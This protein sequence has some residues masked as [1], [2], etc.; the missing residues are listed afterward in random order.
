MSNKSKAYGILGK[1]DLE[2]QVNQ[3]FE[4]IYDQNARR[5]L[6]VCYRMLGDEQS[7]R[8]VAQD[9]W[10]KAYQNLAGFEG[11]SS[12]STWLYRIAVNEILNYLK[13][14]KRRRK[15][16]QL[17][18]RA[19]HPDNT[20]ESDPFSQIASSDESPLDQLQAKDRENIIW[21]LIQKLPEKQKIPLILFRYESLSYQEVADTMGI[22]LQAVESRLHRAKLNLQELLEPFFKKI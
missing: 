13:K 16:S 10:I 19:K 21:R 7:A 22:S 8:D 5:I 4:Q 18:S 20:E 12:L 11:K 14:E 17:F 15:R 9:V 1:V 2:K 6:N 3:G